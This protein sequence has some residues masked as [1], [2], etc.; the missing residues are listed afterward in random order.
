MIAYSALVRSNI[1]KRLITKGVKTFGYVNKKF[2]LVD[3][4]LK[5]L[6]RNYIDYTTLGIWLYPV[7]TNEETQSNAQLI[8]GLTIQ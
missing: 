1:T 4:F 2:N 7:N 8:P 6:L 5:A 3:K